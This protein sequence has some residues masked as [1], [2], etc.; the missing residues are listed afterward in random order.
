[1]QS[2]TGEIQASVAPT[3][4][5]RH[6]RRVAAVRTALLLL[7]TVLVTCA[8]LNSAPTSAQE[9]RDTNRIPF[10]LVAS[11]DMPD[12][13]FQQTVILMLPPSEMPI[14]AGIVINKPTK[15]TLGQLFS[16]SPAIRNQAQSVYFGGPVDLTSPAILMRA[17]RAPDATTR[18][19]ENVYMSD[20]A[21]S[22]RGFLERPES[23]KDIRLFV[24]RAQWTVDQLH[25][26]ILHGAWI[27]TAARPELVFSPDPAGIWQ[28]LVQQ[29]KLRQVE[30]NF[31]VIP[32]ASGFCVS[33]TARS[34]SVGA[35]C[36][37][38]SE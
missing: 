30:W 24:G 5:E 9:L 17:S 28:E 26:E 10:L 16:H 7:A 36:K 25:S 33:A 27:V 4:R 34:A 22:I 32:E 15:M 11:P 31:G 37:T 38:R 29:A 35:R 12:P 1:M 19:F 23:D 20:D 13:L 3:V 8:A 18:V 2:S 21:G 6:R 14:V